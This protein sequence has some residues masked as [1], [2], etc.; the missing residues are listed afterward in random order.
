MQIGY[1]FKKE[2]VTR[3]G[4]MS[5][6]T[7]Y[8][9]MDI[10]APF[11]RPQKYKLKK[12]RDEAAHDNAPDFH[13]YMYVNG[14]GENLRLPRVGALW[15]KES[16]S[17]V[18][19]MSGHIETPFGEK[20]RVNISLFSAKPNYDAEAVTWLYD[21]VWSY[22][23]RDDDDNDTSHYNAPGY[24]PQ[25]TGSKAPVVHKDKEGRVIMPESNLPEIDLN[26]D[27]IPF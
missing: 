27:E 3:Q 16:D 11:T 26:T 23:E 13:I 25:A 2:F 14:R 18:K 24:D 9:E 10:R 5:V 21:V 1:V 8:L 20:G 19:Y 7:A 6:S 22:Y 4:E 12:N 17:G 15:L